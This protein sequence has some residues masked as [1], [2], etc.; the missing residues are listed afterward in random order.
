MPQYE[1]V[2][3]SI[4]VAELYAGKRVSEETEIAR[5][6][7][8]LEVWAV[9]N[10]IGKSAGNLV[11]R[12]ARKG[13]TIALPDALIAATALVHDCPVMT[14]NRTDFASTGVVLIEDPQNI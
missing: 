7:A 3:S 10:E 6:V 9:T 11:F 4:N 2:T 5:L 13:K 1:M 14:A 8:E 12:A